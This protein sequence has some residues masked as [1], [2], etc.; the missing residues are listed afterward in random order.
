MDGYGVPNS[1]AY[2]CNICIDNYFHYLCITHQRYEIGGRNQAA[3][4]VC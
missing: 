2:T 4:A 3:K 1:Y